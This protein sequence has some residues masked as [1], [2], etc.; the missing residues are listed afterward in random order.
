MGT[1]LL[2]VS[3]VGLGFLTSLLL[4]HMLGAK[5]YGAY[6][7]A[8]S[9][10]DFINVFVVF[11]LPVLT[12]KQVS[13]YSSKKKWGYLRG[14]LKWSERVILINAIIAAS[15]SFVIT[16]IFQ[17]HLNHEM[18]LPFRIAV[19][20]L[21]FLGLLQLKEAAIQGLKHII[22]GQI[23]S[24]T[25]RPLIFL[26]VIAIAY[27]SKINLNPSRTI[28]LNIVAV[29]VALVFSFYILRNYLPPEIKL[30]KAKYKAKFW[31]KSAL[32]L[33]LSG[34][35]GLINSQTD[36]IMLGAMKGAYA[37]GIYA[38][39]TRVA[40]LIVFILASVNAA[41]APTIAELYAKNNLKQL[42][43]VIT[44]S[45]RAVFFLSLP[46]AVFL[47]YKGKLALWLFGKEFMAGSSTLA[48]L[49]IGQLINASAGSVGLILAMT[50]HEKDVAFGV[51]VSAV[52]NVILNAMLIPH[53]GAKGAAIAT[54][55]S[56]I[57]W[58][59]ILG[60]Y[61]YKRTRLDPTALGAW[62]Q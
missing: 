32:P 41:M 25:I 1:F 31:I 14:F 59:I 26:I 42:Q 54:S 43:N 12:T 5:G 22:M 36:I 27:F 51:G 35:L 56:M 47:I 10:V 45:A 34:V 37:T 29:I 61:V 21:P 38:V 48:I 40:T 18:L 53:L 24:S 60:I 58:N 8:L 62:K 30:E 57:M 28:E 15:L 6:A 3:S 23:S 44:K 52:V 2:K 50:G 46:I 39:A 7:Y 19:L 4:A 33:L 16:F 11:G 20:L 9:L 13:I 55:T 49:S 17:S